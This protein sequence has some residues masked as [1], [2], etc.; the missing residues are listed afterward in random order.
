M[1]II[2]SAEL[3]VLQANRKLWR[4]ASTGKALNEVSE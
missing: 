1:Y 4:N 2:E 3:Y